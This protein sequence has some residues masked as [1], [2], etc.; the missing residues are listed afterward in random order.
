MNITWD[1]SRLRLKTEFPG[2]R[3][4]KHKHYLDESKPYS[5]HPYEHLSI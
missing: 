3:R 2:F 4:A 1:D 5:T